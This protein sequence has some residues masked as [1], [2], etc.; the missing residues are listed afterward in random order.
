VFEWRKLGSTLRL[1]VSAKNSRAIHLYRKHGFST[2][3]QKA[4][5]LYMKR[6]ILREAER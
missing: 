5:F 6:H 4:G 3:E 2:Y 1:E